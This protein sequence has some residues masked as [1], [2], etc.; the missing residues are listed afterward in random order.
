MRRAIFVSC[1][2]LL[3][4]SVPG[5]AAANPVSKRLPPLPP[6]NIRYVKG[7]HPCVKITAPWP[8]DGRVVV[9]QT[10]RGRVFVRLKDYDVRSPIDNATPT[11]QIYAFIID[12]PKSLP[13]RFEGGFTC[14]ALKINGREV[15]WDKHAPHAVWKNYAWPGASSFETGTVWLPGGR[16]VIEF[17]R[18]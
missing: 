11:M 1:L 10:P 6:N 12:S 16:N 8:D 7:R 18:S 4:L 14:T 17:V 3:S 2:G 5:N 13:V 15:A 9:G